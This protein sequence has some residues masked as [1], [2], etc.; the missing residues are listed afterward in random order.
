VVH[1]NVGEGEELEKGSGT[2]EG[3]GDE[4][5]LVFSLSAFA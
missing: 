5:G 1:E 4:L 3:K 2:G